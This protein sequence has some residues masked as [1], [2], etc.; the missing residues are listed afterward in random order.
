MIELIP[1]IDLKA[2]KCVR[3]LQGRMDTETVF[4]EDPADA[5][6][7]W[8]DLGAPRLHLVDLDGAVSGTPQNLASIERI[9]RAVSVPVQVG[10]GIRDRQR[11]ALYLGI[12]VDR[13]VIGTMACRDPAQ[14]RR[15]SEEFPSRIVLGLDAR[16]GLVAVKGWTELTDLRAVD[17]LAS[18]CRAP[19]GAVI[20]TDIQRDGMLCGPNLPAL[21]AVLAASPWPVIAS[22]GVTSA[23]DVRALARLEPEGLKGVIIGR[24]LYAGKMTFS[25]ALSA[26]SGDL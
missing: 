3:L 5:A 8:H 7:M 24:A 16:E 25:Q 11:A 22:G 13:V 17:L 14:A 19:L 2:G 1:A 18:L 21:K 6:R 9:I 15:L 26:A 20:Y 23:E 12:G 10:G 4:Y